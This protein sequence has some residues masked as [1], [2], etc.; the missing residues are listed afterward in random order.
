MIVSSPHAGWSLRIDEAV[1]ETA[2]EFVGP[3]VF[4]DELNTDILGKQLFRLVEEL[5]RC[6]LALDL[7]N[8]GYLTAHTLGVLLVVH[9]KLQALGGRLSLCNVLPHIHEILAL[10]R[11]T[12]IFS[13]G[14]R[15][16]NPCAAEAQVVV[17]VC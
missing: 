17:A 16:A 7:G 8:V 11:L 5:G 10:T 15:E 1:E 3:Q 13:V 6:R 12:R 14:S 2:V 4:L 9:K